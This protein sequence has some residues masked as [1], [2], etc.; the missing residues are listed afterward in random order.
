MRD[1]YNI[2]YNGKQMGGKKS[3]KCGKTIAYSSSMK[4]HKDTRTFTKQKHEKAKELEI[5]CSAEVRGDEKWVQKL[6]AGFYKEKL[7]AQILSH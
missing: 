1:I 7:S 5:P 4:C 6:D 3:R 2:L